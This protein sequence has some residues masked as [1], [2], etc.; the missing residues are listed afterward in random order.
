MQQFSCCISKQSRF[1]PIDAWFQQIS[2]ASC[3]SDKQVFGTQQR[4]FWL[5]IHQIQILAFSEKLKPKLIP[6]YP[7]TSMK[8]NVDD[9]IKD[10]F[11][12]L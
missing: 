4:N 5:R 8:L 1:L 9:S 7:I 3:A 6:Y 12:L 10:N 2:Y 11:S